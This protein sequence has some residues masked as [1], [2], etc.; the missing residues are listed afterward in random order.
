MGGLEKDIS[1]SAGWISR[2]L[3]SSGY[4]A[5]FS[6]DSLREVDRYFDDQ[7]GP[8][9]LSG[10][11]AQELGDRIFALGSYMGEVVRRARGGEW[12]VE[13]ME[14]IFDDGTRCR[15]V[16]RAMKRMINGRRD[17]VTAWGA[18]LG[19]RMDLLGGVRDALR[20][21]LGR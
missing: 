20:R 21:A 4:R 11:P 13:E 10:L 3:Q 1:R 18:G 19:L 15:P 7:A 8:E 5:D 6:P 14:L 17:S 9:G 2:V 12:L 16:Q